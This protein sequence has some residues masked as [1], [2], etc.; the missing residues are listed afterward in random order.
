LDITCSLFENQPQTTM[1]KLLNLIPYFLALVVIGCSTPSN[2]VIQT[3]ADVTAALPYIRPGAAVAC[4]AVLALAVSNQDR[5]DVAGDI[6]AIGSVIYSLSGGQS[7]TPA[8]LQAAIAQVAP[9]SPEF[10]I[11]A[12]TI[13]GI[14]AGL[15]PQITGDPKLAL[16]VLNDLAGGCDDAASAYIATPIPATPT[17]PPTAP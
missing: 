17:P 15:Y 16:Q 7:V 13:E 12:T 11:L 9:K 6:Y 8:Q 3:Q 1:K 14:Y 5:A 10:G 2:G 4:S